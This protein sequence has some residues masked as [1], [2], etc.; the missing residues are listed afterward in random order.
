MSAPSYASEP[1]VQYLHQILEQMDR[2]ELLIPDFQRPPRWTDEQRRRLLESVSG[3]YPIG[4]LMV[5]RTTVVIPH[6]T[7]IGPHRI[8]AKVGA[9]HQY[10]YLLDGFQRMSTLLAALGTVPKPLPPEPDHDG[11]RWLLGYH[12]LNE[13][14]VF[15]NEV[16]EEDHQVV[17]PGYLLLDSIRLLRAQRKLMDHPAVE[18]LLERSDALVRSLR[19]YKLAVIPMVTDELHEAVRTF[20]LLNTEGTR[21]SDLDLVV[22]ISWKHDYDLRGQLDDAKDLL[23]L[24]GWEE[25]DEKYVMA[26]LRSAFDL[27]LYDKD[28][29]AKELGERLR[30]EPDV[31]VAAVTG[32]AD[33]GRF[34][35]ER[36]GVVALELL[37]YSYQ[38]V[39]LGDVLRRHPTRSSALDTALVQW[40]WWTTAW[41]TFAGISGYRMN[42]MIAYLRALGEGKD[43]PWP[44]RM[45]E[46]K[47][48]SLPLTIDPR[49]A[50]T[51]ATA[52][53]LF[54]TM[55][56]TAELSHRLEAHAGRALVRG[57]KG[58]P[59]TLARDPGNAFL[60]SFEDEVPLLNALEERRQ[61]RPTGADG[62]DQG[63]MLSKFQI[64]K[65]AWDALGRGDT[66]GFVKGRRRALE[67]IEAV[68]LEDLGLPP[69]VG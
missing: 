24:V 57:L 17:L 63:D 2:A 42:A 66:K 35:S 20:G 44:W 48:T 52:L 22:A 36:C 33:A 56:Q 27:A 65:D 60:V 59:A 54:R 13:E 10:Q 18:K 64:S 40:F 25:L 37:P 29:N 49:A 12:L 3:G 4:S 68:F 19:E 23:S 51:R 58:L 61:S 7:Q 16:D 67:A 14:W 39:L 31:L 43:V 5:W 32:L 55:G 28:A 47:P 26:A 1:Q 62:I 69:G 8:S 46:V 50:R 38:A 53:H 9:T 11:H 21:M 15:L 34:L 30:S 45:T 6:R 41:A